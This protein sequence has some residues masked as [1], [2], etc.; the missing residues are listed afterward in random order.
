MK[1]I[2]LI[3][4]FLVVGIVIGKKYGDKLPGFGFSE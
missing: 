3:L 1:A 4:L 2:F